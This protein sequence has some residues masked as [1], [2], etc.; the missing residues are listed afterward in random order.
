MKICDFN[1]IYEIIHKSTIIIALCRDASIL[2]EPVTRL[3][4]IATSVIARSA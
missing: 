4:V 3:Y 2:R 1:I